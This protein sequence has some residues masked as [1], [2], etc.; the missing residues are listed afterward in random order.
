M[1]Y[2]TMA[3]IGGQ[4][5]YLLAAYNKADIASMERAKE[6]ICDILNT[7]GHKEIVTQIDKWVKERQMDAELNQKK[8][9]DIESQ[10]QKVVNE[11]DTLEKTFWG[12]IRKLLLSKFS[13]EFSSSEETSYEE[14]VGQE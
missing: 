2:D 9:M 1:N 12:N 14:T 4:M 7:N 3:H 11:F 10:K 8:L 5:E 6:Q 13:S